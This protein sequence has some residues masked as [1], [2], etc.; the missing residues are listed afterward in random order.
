MPA[1]YVT[2]DG[3][4]LGSWLSVR[5]QDYKA[6]KLSPERIQQLEALGVRWSLHQIRPDSEP[7]A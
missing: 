1:K 4:R 6:G 7:P 2:S 3:Y 5:R